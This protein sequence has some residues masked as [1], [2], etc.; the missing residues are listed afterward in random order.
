V[1]E[2]IAAFRGVHAAAAAE[3][4]QGVGIEGF[5][6]IAAGFDVGFGGVDVGAFVNGDLDAGGFEGSVARFTWP[7]ATMPGSVTRRRFFA[8]REATHSGSSARRPGPKR[9]AGLGRASKGMQDRGWVKLN[10]GEEQ[11][12]LRF[13][14]KIFEISVICWNQSAEANDS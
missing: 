14:S 1:E 11:S 9:M 12:N 5:G 10:E 6:E 3:A 7:A 13:P 4:D 2:E 8:P